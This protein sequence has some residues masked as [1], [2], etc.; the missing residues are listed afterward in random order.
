MSQYGSVI[1]VRVK[2]NAKTHLGIGYHNG[3]LQQCRFSHVVQITK[4]SIE[5][6]YL[7][8]KARDVMTDQ[9]LL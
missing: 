3:R 1:H 5:F 8:P 7:Y 4:S 9:L 6:D 2:V